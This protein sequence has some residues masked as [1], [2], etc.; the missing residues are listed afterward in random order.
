MHVGP[1]RSPVFIG[2]RP[3]YPYD[4]HHLLPGETR[5]VASEGGARLGRATHSPR[6]LLHADGRASYNGHRRYAGL[7]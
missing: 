1:H 7:G 5:R 4:Q 2:A 6:R 3:I